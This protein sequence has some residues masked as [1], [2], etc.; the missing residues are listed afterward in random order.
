MVQI[1]SALAVL[2]AAAA[3]VV[4]A[5][6]DLGGSYSL[7]VD[8][9]DSLANDIE[10]TI[11]SNVEFDEDRRPFYSLIPS[12]V[13][14]AFHQCLGGR[15]RGC[16][17]VDDP[18][19]LHLRRVVEAL[20]PVRQ[21]NPYV[22]YGDLWAFAGIVALRV[23]ERLTNVRYG[24]SH[25]YA[26]QLL[27][28][29]FG[30]DDC[31]TAPYTREVFEFPS[32]SLGLDHVLRYFGNTFGLSEGES[33][34]LLGAHT[35]GG[36]RNP[37]T[38]GIH[39]QWTD[40]PDLLDNSFFRGM[41][42][43]SRRWQQSPVVLPGQQSAIYFWGNGNSRRLLFNADL[44][45]YK[46]LLFDGSAGGRSLCT[47]DTCRLSRTALSVNRFAASNDVWLSSFMPAYMKMTE[48]GYS[49]QQ[50]RAPIVIVQPPPQKHCLF[51]FL[52]CF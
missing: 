12:C 9:R 52:F 51:W 46:D 13:R 31:P 37:L 14:L 33:V 43:G 20:E 30:R 40:T 48:R 39:R 27:T 16:I 38:G 6:Y 7:T 17:N 1:A 32:F 8:Q 18:N 49:S 22:R 3:F 44:C 45:L 36:L 19:N 41:I 10:S 35:L 29:R 15:C 28:F 42:D 4:D 47:Y 25:T 34:A 2:L 11:L 21:R 5:T 23:S 26:Q 50:L 24:R